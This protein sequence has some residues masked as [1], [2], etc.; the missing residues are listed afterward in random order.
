MTDE[1]MN[2][3]QKWLTE[4]DK[5][6]EKR[7]DVLSK[8]H[9]AHINALKKHTQAQM[10]TRLNEN[11]PDK[12]SPSKMTAKNRAKHLTTMTAFEV[13]KMSKVGK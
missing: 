8:A 9:V 1:W 7:K 11:N 12:S 3:S 10:R 4:L 5:F 6:L 2:E 13:F